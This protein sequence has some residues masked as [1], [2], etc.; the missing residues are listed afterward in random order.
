MKSAVHKSFLA[1][2]CAAAMPWLLLAQ[3]TL[4]PPTT[5]P[6]NERTAGSQ[7]ERDWQELL[8]S[9]KQTEREG[10]EKDGAD[11][12]AARIAGNRS[13]ADKARE[14]YT[15]HSSDALA[16]E[17]RRLEVLALIGALE[18]GDGASSGRLEQAVAS[19]R[20]DRQVP[21]PIRAQ[22]VAAFEF[23]REL[24]EVRGLEARMDTT[25]RVARALIREFP[26]EAPGYEALWA[27]A[28]ASPQQESA[29][30]AQELLASDAPPPLKAAAQ[31]LLARYAL[32]GR[33][34]ASVL[35]GD[36]GLKALAN[37]PTGTPLIVY[38]WASWGPGSLDFGRMIQARRFAA[39]GVCLDQDIAEAGRLAHSLGLGGEHLFDERGLQGPAAARLNFSTAGQIYLVD[40]AGVIRDVRGGEDFE[41]KLGAFGFRT[42]TLNPSPEQ[43]RP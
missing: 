4:P 30:L 19:L 41:T 40:E 24:R 10:R 28:K 37:L 38:S 32:I 42:P 13:V 8:E 11:G 29:K 18:E 36:S 1:A 7:S 16:A 9:R 5:P 39:L 35:D 27:V 34:L 14:F 26:G 6:A 12:R 17:A 23:T 21:A 22:G 3:I 33:P 43:L 15:T 2:A 25:G 31:T 20:S